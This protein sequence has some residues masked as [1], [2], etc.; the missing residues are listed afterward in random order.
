MRVLILSDLHIAPYSNYDSP[1][2]VNNFC[3]FIKNGKYYA[4]TLILILG[5]IIRNDGKSGEMAFGAADKIFSYIESELTDVNYKIAFIPGNHDYCNGTLDAFDQ[6]CR[7][8]QTATSEP[9]AFSYGTTF[10]Y[11]IGNFNFIFTDSI[12]EKNFG[13]AGRLDLDSLHACILAD[14]ENILFMHHSLLSEDSSDHTGII[15]QP[16]AMDFLKQHGVKFVFHGHAH[17]MRDFVINGD[18]KLFGV[19]SM[20]VED[21]GIDNEKEQFLEVQINGRSIEAVANWLW[22][23]GS[24]RYRKDCIYPDWLTEYDSGDLIQRIPYENPEN[25]IERYVLPRDIASQDEVTRYFSLDKKTTLFDACMKERLVLFIADAGLGKT[26]EMQHLAYVVTCDKPYLRPIFLS[27]NVYAGESIGDYLNIWAPDYKTMDPDQFVLIMDGYDEL[28]DPEAFKKALFKYVAENSGT[29]I[30]ISMRSNFLAANSSLSKYFSIYQLLELG[31]ADV[32][33]ELQNSGIDKYAFYEECEGKNLRM[34]LPNPFYLGKMIEIY[35]MDGS[36]PNQANLIARFI[37]IQFEKDA[38]KFEFAKPIAESRYEVERALTRF[39]YGMQLLNCTNCDEKTYECILEEKDDRQ[40]IK[41]SSLTIITGTGH[42]FEHN[43]FKEYLVAKHVSQMSPTKIIEQV[44]IPGTKYLNPNWFNVLGLVLQLNSNKELESWI[45]GAEPLVLTRLEP[46][47]ITPEQR[48]S[49]LTSALDDITSKNIWFRNEICSE[50]QLATFTQ[51]PDA[52]DLL[53]RHIEAPA[54]FRSLYFCLSVLLNFPNL[55]GSDSKVRDLLV[56]CYQSGS[57]R[58]HEKRVAISAIATLKLNTPEITEDLIHRF[59]ESRSSYER[60][61]VYEYLQQSHLCDVN[62]DFLL[63]GIKYLSYSNQN[64]EILNGTEHF[65]LIECLNSISDPIAIEK[66]IRWYSNKD[67]IDIDFYDR[68][69]LFSNLFDKATDAYCHGYRALFGTVYAFFINATRQYSRYHIPDALKF[70]STTGTIGTAFTQLVSED[71]DDRLFMI[72]DTIQSQPELIDVFC[73]LY[74]EDQLKDQSIFREYTLR[75]QS[76]STLFEKCAYLIRIKKGEVLEPIE[77][78]PDYNL[79]RRRDVQTFFDCLFD[80]QSMRILLI[81]LADFYGN[82][83]I[84]FEQV[85]ESRTWHERYPEG[86]RTL[87]TALIQSCFKEKRVIDFVDLIDWDNFIIN[88]ICY[89]F[90]NERALD[91]LFISDSQRNVLERV[92]HQLEEKLDYHTAVE[93]PDLN[94]YRFSWELYDYMVIKDAL[95]LPSPDNYYL[96]LLE[97]PCG[98]VNK[99]SNVGEKYALIEQ[100]IISSRVALRVEELTLQESRICVLEDL[101]FGCKRYQIKSCKDAAIQMCKRDEVSAYSRRN[102]LE[103]LFSVF[104]SELVLNV[105]MPETDDALFELIVDMLRENPDS[106]LKAEMIKRYKI[107][108]NRFLLKNLIALNIPEGLQ[109]YIEKSKEVNGI[110]DCSDE[111]GEVTEAISAIQDISLLPLLLDAV[112]MRFSDSFKD[113]SFH[114]LYSSLQNALSNCAKSDFTLVWK[115]IN[116]LKEEL[117]QDSEAISF[118]SVLQNSIIEANKMTLVKKWSAYE[119]RSVLRDI[120]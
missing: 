49:I 111:I 100:H 66:A 31:N 107:A 51:S 43:I 63:Q 62:V 96:G 50:K 80:P 110:F 120:D 25:Y 57:V 58:S 97:I 30:C 81:R 101:M 83:E 20:G 70:F 116:R 99:Q 18:C 21:P 74:A 113:G 92:Y 2:W 23:G 88:R 87:E 39:A 95:N 114:T 53:I 117:S 9:F 14:K 93:E 91:S 104:G 15:Q 44:S 103:Y 47:C 76:N 35:L 36:L 55:Y 24:K 77:P 54:H 90:K 11:T 85:R 13:I 6:F 106:R 61:G 94:S 102:A 19:G 34:L 52:V 86:T 37:D 69:K 119:V 98:F 67:H 27:L 7:R 65:T 32:E 89:L 16:Q 28:S 1:P 41:H 4:D 78:Q 3:S 10:N 60:L 115:S 48:Y 40:N 26:V 12:R 79:Q 59:A 42:G 105:I 68:E 33:R 71:A 72:E 5:D 45:M 118:C 109:F 82:Q 29:H 75:H 8:H 112:R 73:R 17:A 38:E 46:D 108:P 64:D 22:R 84:T 56:N